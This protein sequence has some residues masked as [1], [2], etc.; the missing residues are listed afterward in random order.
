M[1]NEQVLAEWRKSF[2][3]LKL[4]GVVCE[5]CGEHEAEY[6]NAT[7]DICRLCAES[8]IEYGRI[9]VPEAYEE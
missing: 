6:V 9:H 8:A 4:R 2:D 7:G 1:T 3:S 5:N